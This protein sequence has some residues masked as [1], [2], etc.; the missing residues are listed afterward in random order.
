M[1]KRIK[2]CRTEA[3]N[4][5]IYRKTSGNKKKWW[6]REKEKEGWKKGRVYQKTSQ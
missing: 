3:K 1:E 6:S 4:K 5:E 2:E